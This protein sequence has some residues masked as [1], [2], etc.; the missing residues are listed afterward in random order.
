MTDFDIILI[1]AVIWTLI[2]FVNVILEKKGIIPGFSKILSR[3]YRGYNV[4]S[5]SGIFTGFSW[6]FLDGLITGV[7]IVLILRLM[8][9]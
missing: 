1:V 9:N 6:A 2:F 5:F 8:N 4:D 3:V 7:I